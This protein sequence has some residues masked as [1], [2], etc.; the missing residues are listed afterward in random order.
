MLESG[1]SLARNR[2]RGTL[3]LRQ[4]LSEPDT[5]IDSSGTLHFEDLEMNPVAR[6]SPFCRSHA[7]RG[8]P[9]LCYKGILTEC[10]QPD[11]FCKGCFV[12]SPERQSDSTTL[13]NLSC[14][15][16]KRCFVL[17]LRFCSKT[18]CRSLRPEKRRGVT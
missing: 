1:G 4:N 3:G 2:T 11:G 10:T 9:H 13:T 15:L 16:C 7:V 14:K 17:S 5:R 12:V 18:L 6:P 8:T